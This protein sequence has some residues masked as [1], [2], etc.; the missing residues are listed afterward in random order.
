MSKSLKVESLQERG[1]SFRANF[2]K[3]TSCL[4]PPDNFSQG[5]SSLALLFIIVLGIFIL[6]ETN[7]YI[8]RYVASN[9]ESA[10][11]LVDEEPAPVC[12]TGEQDNCND[13]ND[14]FLL[15]Q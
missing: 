11:G 3:T 4:L 1:N 15:S 8:N 6:W 13:S 10:P 7:E 14:V 9:S 2:R 12:K 5:L